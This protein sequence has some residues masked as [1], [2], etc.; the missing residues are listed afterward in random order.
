MND[1]K[2]IKIWRKRKKTFTVEVYHSTDSPR[3]HFGGNY[4]H[5]YVFIY[6]GHP[7]FS[8]LEPNED[9]CQELSKKIP[10]HRSASFFHA[11]CTSKGEVTSYQIGCDYRHLYDEA[12]SFM[13][14]EEEAAPVFA[15]A[16]KLLE[17]LE[18]AAALSIPPQLKN[19]C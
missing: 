12:Y 9:V 7:L 6:P 14:T 15:D 16:E 8:Q 1:W 2:K 17:Y 18:A 13:E 4:W 3:G 5:I 11:H 19:N 10:F